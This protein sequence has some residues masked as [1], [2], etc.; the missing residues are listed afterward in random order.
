MIENNAPII[1]SILRIRDVQA[2]TGLSRPTLYKLIQQG[3]FPS[4]LDL[5]G[6]GRAVGWTEA[7][8][9]GWIN[10]RVQANQKAAG[11]KP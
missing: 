6:T 9:V 3:R 2:R 7:S 1:T 4:G 5:L 11:G 10:E 8:I